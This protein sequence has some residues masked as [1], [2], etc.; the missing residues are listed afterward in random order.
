MT[1]EAADS[2]DKVPPTVGPVVM[3]RKPTTMTCFV[4]K[5]ESA[6][7]PLQ[8]W[9][10]AETGLTVA[11][12]AEQVFHAWTAEQGSPGTARLWVSK[13]QAF[14]T[15][16]H[17]DAVV[18]EPD[19]SGYYPVAAEVLAASFEPTDTSTSRLEA[20]V[21][22][23]DDAELCTAPGPGE[24]CD[25]YTCTSCGCSFTADGSVTAPPGSAHV[26]AALPSTTTNEE[27]DHG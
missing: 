18:R 12:V 6:T 8:R 16:K 11:Q 15:I 1:A 20:C 23:G 27:A 14:C 4:W 3:R 7:A 9:L 5:D 19:W 26:E 22:C 13:S 25:E 24:P 21:L 10:A 17:G 2:R